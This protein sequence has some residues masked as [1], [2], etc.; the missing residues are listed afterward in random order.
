MPI[1][2]N[3]RRTPQIFSVRYM[4]F[5]LFYFVV[6]TLPRTMLL[7][8][9]VPELSVC[10]LVCLLGVSPRRLKVRIWRDLLLVF[11]R[12]R[13]QRCLNPSYADH[14]LKGKQIGLSV[15]SL[16]GINSCVKTLWKRTADKVFLRHAIQSRLRGYEMPLVASLTKETWSIL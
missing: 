10:L 6:Y 9:I 12:S 16:C 5:S 1:F 4:Q 3:L 2:L 15:D 11:D 8:T 13:K 14:K 7:K